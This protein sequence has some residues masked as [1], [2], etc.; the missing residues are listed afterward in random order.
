MTI[1][2]AIAKLIPRLASTFDGE[3]VATVRAIERALRSA[4][5]D[6]HDLAAAAVNGPSRRTQEP[7]RQSRPHT[8]DDWRSLHAGCLDHGRGRLRSREWDFVESL[9]QWRGDLSEK[10]LKWLRDIAARLGRAS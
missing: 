1:P 5:Y 9:T 4:G 8:D 2:A 3:V 6:L 7:P 10:Q